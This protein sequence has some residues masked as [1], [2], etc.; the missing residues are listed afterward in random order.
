MADPFAYKRDAK[1]QARLNSEVDALAK[2]PDNAC[3]ADC[4]DPKRIRFCSVTLGIFLCNR[5]Y[6]LHRALGAHVTRVKCLGLDAWKPEEVDLLR[7]RG[8]ARASSQYEATIPPGHQRPT[9]SSPD[10]EV[11]TWIRDK[12]E[13]KKY[14][15]EAATALAPPMP[16]AVPFTAAATAARAPA[17][18]PAQRVVTRTPSAAPEVDLL[19]DLLCGASMQSTTAPPAPADWAAAFTAARPPAQQWP[20]GSTSMPTQSPTQSFA[21]QPTQWP[22]MAPPVA[23]PMQQQHYEQQQQQQLSSYPPHAMQPMMASSWPS[24]LTAF[25]PPATMVQPT[26]APVMMPSAVP[27]ATTAQG[28][29]GGG[30]SAGACAG[31]GGGLSNDD[32][33]FL[34]S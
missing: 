1:L 14:Y 15:Q 8:N 13:R 2:Q 20:A 30:R 27:A 3:C 16:A 6:G 7:A 31:G 12:Y 29:G 34:L 21:S 17:A 24:E 18:A 23:P 5:C 25:T 32:M 33:L 9:V 19:G 26:S 4:G 22:G 10:R 11:A 28:Q